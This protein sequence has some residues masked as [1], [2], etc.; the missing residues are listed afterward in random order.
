[1]QNPNAR[2][3]IPEDRSGA[4]HADVNRAGKCQRQC[5]EDDNVVRATMLRRLNGAKE[6]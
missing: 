2:A 5:G 1:M 4:R 6:N 3:M